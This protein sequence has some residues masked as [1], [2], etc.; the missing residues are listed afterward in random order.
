MKTLFV[1]LAIV[2][3]QAAVVADEVVK[4]PA[5]NVPTT[6]TTGIGYSFLPTPTNAGFRMDGYYV[7]CGS[8]IKAD[9]KFHLFASRW[10]EGTGKG[11]AGKG[12][13]GVGMLDGYR[14]YSEIVHAVADNP[15]GPYTFKEVVLHGRGG[16]WW[17]GQMC[18]NPKIVKVGDTFV[19]YYIGSAVGSPLRKI[20]Y[21]WAKSV[22]G[23]WTR[24]DDC[25]PLGDDQ[26]NPAPF[27]HEDG[28]VMLAYRNQRQQMFIASAA[29][30][31]GKYETIAKNICPQAP[32]EDPD[33]TFRDRLYHLVA[34]DG[35]GTLTGHERFGAELVS[36]DGVHWEMNDPVTAYTHTIRWADGTETVVDRRERPEFFNADADANRKGSGQPTHLISAVQVGSHTWCNVVPLATPTAPRP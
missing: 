10:P 11:G 20:G 3:M 35:K 24:I 21:A 25:L 2:A 30:W 31:N 15:V 27:V 26:N 5:A 1:S 6:G 18:H 17:D 12:S 22:D 13:A 8:L 19:L 16:K 14:Q 34:E 32:L 28:R 29:A 36:K 7:W 33:L 23:P 9:G 4:P